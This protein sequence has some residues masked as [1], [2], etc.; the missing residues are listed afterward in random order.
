MFIT[1]LCCQNKIFFLKIPN[2]E[3]YRTPKKPVSSQTKTLQFPYS[4]LLQVQW[5]M[6]VTCFW[7]KHFINLRQRGGLSGLACMTTSVTGLVWKVICLI[8]TTSGNSISDK[9]YNMY[10]N[11]VLYLNKILIWGWAESNPSSI[12]PLACIQYLDSIEYCL[13][14]DDATH[15]SFRV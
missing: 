4:Q 10:G 14:L 9:K 11:L 8:K 13:I 2:I 1:I 5:Y 7:S 12:T 3:P 15:V 6:I